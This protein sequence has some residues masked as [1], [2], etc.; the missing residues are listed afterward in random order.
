M[1]LTSIAVLLMLSACS[2]PAALHYYQLA[3]V[4]A[5]TRLHSAAATFYVAPVQ[6]ASYLNGRGLVLQQSDVELNMARQHL[7]AEPLDQQVQRQLRELL[8]AALPYT[9]ALSMQPDTIVVSVQLD[10]FHGTADGYAVLSGR[11]QLNTQTGSEPFTIR[12]PLAADGY[13]ALVTALG[14]GL[15]QLSEQISLAIKPAV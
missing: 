13:P 2:G 15:R 6:V 4:P 7:W 14:S 10:R 9:A 5:S 11:Y 1:R 3:P 12:V 8:A